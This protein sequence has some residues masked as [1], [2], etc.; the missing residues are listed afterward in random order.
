[1]IPMVLLLV[2]G[3]YGLSKTY[4]QDRSS[5][6]NRIVQKTED[7]LEEWNIIREKKFEFGGEFNLQSTGF[8][9]GGELGG[10]VKESNSLAMIVESSIPLYLKGSITDIYTG[11]S[12]K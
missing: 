6:M 10:N 7:K 4:R 12:W 8:R 11:R 2:L 9:P 3:S 1:M 5:Q